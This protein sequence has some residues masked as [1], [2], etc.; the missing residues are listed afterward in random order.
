MLGFADSEEI[1]IFFEC[2]CYL[3]DE[4]IGDVHIPI[5]YVCTRATSHA[6]RFE[7]FEGFE[8]VLGLFLW[9]FADSFIRV[10]EEMR[11]NLLVHYSNTY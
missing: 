4:T 2:W 7:N 8:K 1:C 5:Y 11:I 9:L 10:G 3:F 6:Q